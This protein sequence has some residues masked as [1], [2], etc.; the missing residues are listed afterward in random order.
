M[1][2]CP[3]HRRNCGYH[4]K[5]NVDDEVEDDNVPLEP[6]TR[7]K[8]LIASKTLHNFVVQFEMTPELLDAI[9]KVRHELQ[10]NLKFKRTQ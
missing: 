8:T 10:L 9:R 1:L 7:K 2:K 6:V 3:K 4:R 5:N